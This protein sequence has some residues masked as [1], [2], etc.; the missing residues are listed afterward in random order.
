MS[1]FFKAGPHVRTIIGSWDEK[2][3]PA[4]LEEAIGCDAMCVFHYQGADVFLEMPTGSKPKGCT[5]V[6]DGQ[7]LRGMI[8]D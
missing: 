6:A 8:D 1:E 3:S 7:F 4:Q 5:P 2:I